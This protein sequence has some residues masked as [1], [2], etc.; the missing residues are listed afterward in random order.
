MNT[1]STETIL[2]R[3]QRLYRELSSR[4]IDV[5]VS[6]VFDLHPQ[7]AAWRRS[8][9]FA[10]FFIIGFFITLI[11]HPLSGWFEQLRVLFSSLMAQQSP[12]DVAINNFVKFLLE[13]IT[14]SSILQYLP[15]FIAPFFIAL[16]SAAIYLA[17]IFEL[18]DVNVARSFVSGVALTGR[19]E[20]IRVRNGNVL[21]DHMETPTFLIGGPGKVVVELDSV[22][23][24]ERADGTPHVIGPT[25]KEPG[26]KAT[27]EGFERF[28][29][30][31]DIR[32]H[33]V[34][35]RDQ[36]SKSKA[37]QSRSRDGI[38]IKA[39]DVR[40]MFSI[41]RGEKPEATPEVPYPFSKEAVEQI[42][43]K[44]ASRVTPDQPFPSTYEFNWTQKMPGLIRGK[45]G[46]FMSEHN[47]SEYL[48][49]T[50]MPEFEKAKERE[51]D[52]VE[53]IQRISQSEEDISSG[54]KEIKS[55]PDFQARYKVKNLF[56]QFAEGFS[57]QARSNGVEL[58]WIGVGTWE[59][60]KEIVLD[61]HLDAWKLTQENL[62]SGNQGAMSAV[63][64]SE[65]TKKTKELIQKVPIS[66]FLTMSK[67][68]KSTKFG[69]KGQDI[70]E[71]ESDE[72]EDE[73]VMIDDADP[74]SEVLDI[75]HEM[76]G[77][78]KKKE[79]PPP[80]IN[81]DHAYNAQSLL[82][83]YRKQFQETADLIR[84]KKEEV[85]QTI[86]DA[87]RHIDNQIGHWAGRP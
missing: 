43:F 36:D 9:L 33:H 24:F 5:L 48:A 82:L 18:E 76:H 60:P 86:L 68:V 41:Y 69:G 17:D 52:I 56:A 50:G 49:S 57:G 11:N 83:E 14:D 15:V 87:I 16:Q 53:Q 32:N 61:K 25:G 51:K 71:W 74:M 38:P 42:V 37:V 65:A 19:D 54:R 22:A 40:L 84:N 13:I 39:T 26:G 62:K 12:P 67:S 77:D 30:A 31:F 70:F 75:L 45:L 78:K 20:T 4:L 29:H 8:T 81:K 7:K 80:P 10:L 21:E 46:G 55:P 72:D 44:A 79:A 2:Q 66:V 28:R 58:H 64:N 63:E 27:L 23:L 1:T 35:L 85:P 47:L 6:K 3:E 34:D 73:D 59:S